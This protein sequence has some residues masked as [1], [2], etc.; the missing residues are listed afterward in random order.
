VISITDQASSLAAWAVVVPLAA[1]VAA[2]LCPPRGR[3]VVALAAMAAVPAAVAGLILEVW[4]LGPRRHLLGG[5]AAPLGIELHADGLAALMLGVSAVVAVATGVYATADL[6]RPQR[7]RTSSPEAGPPGGRPHAAAERR[8]PP[9]SHFWVL[10][11]FTWAA[12]NAVFLSADLFNLYVTL[13][14]LGLSAVALVALAGT[15]SAVVAAMRYL[16][17]SLLGSALILAGVALVYAAH[18]T[19][20]LPL[21]R[22]L[23]GD[24][25]GAAVA[26][27]ALTL[28]LL[29]KTAVFPFHGWLAPAHASA[30]PPASALLSGVVVKASF[31]VLLRLWVD[32]FQ[33]TERSALH[34]VAGT[35][36][37]VAI[38]WGSLLALRQSDIKLLVAYSTVAQLGYLMLIFPLLAAGQQLTGHGL[39]A[40]NGGIYHALSHAC[41]KAA[42]FLAAGAMARAAGGPRMEGLSGVGQAMP[43]AASAFG[44]GG[45]SLAGLP[46]SGGFLAKWLLLEAALATRGWPWVAAILAGSLLAAAYVFV[47]LRYVFER[48]RAPRPFARVPRRLELCALALALLAVALGI[49]A[50]TPLALLAVGPHGW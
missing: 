32:V 48:T 46:P 27:V 15:P 34:W 3:L 25:P 19:L 39:T 11:L 47:V 6:P 17:V 30:P 1:A 40:W 45:L 31:Y 43:L 29:M 50:A 7:S 36:G 5:W 18:G 38:V 4:S 44:L 22:G 13:E 14:L 10:W 49:W 2:L 12:L 37:A 16:L 26:L 21:L 33:V 20:S 41:A 9:D 8:A 35:L 42:M 23:L 24:E 28:G